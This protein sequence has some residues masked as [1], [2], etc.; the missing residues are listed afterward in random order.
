M[1]YTSKA[2]GL[3]PNFKTILTNLKTSAK[4]GGSPTLPYKAT[5]MMK[6]T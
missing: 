6:V 1:D 5:L 3:H 4:K 2:Q